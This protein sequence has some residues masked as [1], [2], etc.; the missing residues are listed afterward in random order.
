MSPSDAV[1]DQ[2]DAAGTLITGTR[3]DQLD[4]PTPCSEWAVRDLISHLMAGSHVFGTMLAGGE[5]ELP[6][7][8]P[9]LPEGDLATAWNDARSAFMEGLDS[10]GA[11]ER[12]L[13]MP[14]GR[15]PA[16]VLVDVLK[17]DVLV[18]CHELARATGQQFDPPDDVVEEAYQ[19]ALGAADASPIDSLAAFCGRQV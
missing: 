12:D 5:A 7:R 6:E 4:A 3:P 10:P 13:P 18:H 2:F 16:L 11:T 9:A 14:G 8:P 19:I 1:R 15:L 17:F